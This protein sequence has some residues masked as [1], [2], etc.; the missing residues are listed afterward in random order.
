MMTMIDEQNYEAYLLQYHD[1]TLDEQGVKEVEAFLLQHPQIAREDKQYY[2][3]APL[4][5][6]LAS[7]YLYKGFLKQSRT[8]NQKWWYW[9]AAACVVGLMVAIGLW[10]TP[11]GTRPQP[12]VAQYCT[13]PKEV[14]ARAADKESQQ[15]SL[16][17][18]TSPSTM[19]GTPVRIRQSH[20][21]EP[22]AQETEVG[23]VTEEAVADVTP[24]APAA[25]MLCESDQLVVY[26]CP[27]VNSSSLVQYPDGQPVCNNLACRLLLT[28]RR[29][30]ML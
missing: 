8:H 18:T 11:E 28:G 21:D 10:S 25:P 7:T 16:R 12:I 22:M 3:D 19:V 17:T 13:S 2:C 30:G 4:V 20:P 24:S 26:G 27:T 9:M 23:Q 5:A 15:P 14:M 1:G 29:L 6:P